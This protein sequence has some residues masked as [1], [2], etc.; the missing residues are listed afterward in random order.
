MRALTTGITFFA[1]LFVLLTD[2][3]GGKG[4]TVDVIGS[5]S[6]QPFAEILAEEF[7]EQD[8]DFKVDVQGGGSTVGVRIG[9]QWDER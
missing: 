7:N 4:E 2:W 9:Q 8:H 1:L 3:S 6:V 5:N